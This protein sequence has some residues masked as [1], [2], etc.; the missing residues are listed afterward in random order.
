MRNPRPDID[1]AS[2]AELFIGKKENLGRNDGPEIREWKRLLGPGVEQAKGI[3]WCAIYV[4]G[5]LMQRNGLTDRGELLDALGWPRKKPAYLESCDWILQAAM[6]NG[7]PGLQLVDAPDRN[8]L[9]LLMARRANGSYSKTD[10]RHVY[11]CR[12]PIDQADDLVPT[13]EGNT[14]PGL[15]EGAQ[16]REGQGVYA[17]FRSVEPGRQVF[18]RLPNPLVEVSP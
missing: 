11:I 9:G 5:T 13:V 2:Y 10:A 18:V 17:R 4:F 8:D 3:A 16:S 1:L 12:G 15:V 6:S 7:V 14:M